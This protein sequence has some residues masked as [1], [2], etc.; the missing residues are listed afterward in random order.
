MNGQPIVAGGQ[1]EVPTTGG[2]KE[3]SLMLAQIKSP[4]EL[5]RLA[6][7]LGADEKERWVRGHHR[8]LVRVEQIAGVLCGKP[9]PITITYIDRPHHA[10]GVQGGR[11]GEDSSGL[12]TRIDR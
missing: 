9:K 6:R 3:G 1:E 8:T 2:L 11:V 12:D 4:L 7:A 5:G 10:S